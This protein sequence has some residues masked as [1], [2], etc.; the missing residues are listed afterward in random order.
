[1]KELYWAVIHISYNS[2]T[3]TIQINYH[4]KF[5][6]FSTYPPKETLY[7]FAASPYFLPVPSST[8]LPC[9]GPWQPL[10]LL[11]FSM[12][13]LILDISYTS[14]HTVCDPL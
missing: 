4:H 5:I 14:N 9:I 10:N 13:L 8:P 7:T 12:D 6:T 3:Y 1:M 11:Y 2:F